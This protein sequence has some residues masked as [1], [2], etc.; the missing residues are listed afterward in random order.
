MTI[1]W[2]LAVCDPFHL[3][4]H[5]SYRLAKR[6]VSAPCP[7][8]WPGIQIDQIPDSLSLP[9]KIAREQPTKRNESL[10]LEPFDVTSFVILLD[11]AGSLAQIA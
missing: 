3:L 1:D 11:G 7:A 6:N 9:R 8:D 4:K 10:A 2:K 5:L